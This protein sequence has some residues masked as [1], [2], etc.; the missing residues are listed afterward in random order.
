[1]RA[2]AC[3]VPL[4]VVLGED[5]YLVREGLARLLATR[6]EI[7][8]AAACA[9]GDSVLA[10]VEAE[11]P[12]VVV[13]DIRMPPGAADEGIRLADRLRESHP[14]VGVVVLSQY[15]DAGF[16]LALL[17]G[18][19]AGRAYL[20]KERVHDIDE[21]VAAIG[22]VAA[23][24]SVIDP[25][26]VDGLVQAGPDSQDS[27][28]GELTPREREILAEMARGKNNA[29]IAASLI[30]TEGTVEKYVSS[31]FAKLGISWEKDV[32][33]RV[34]AVLVYLGAQQR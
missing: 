5:D 33:R 21:L 24:R 22:A 15:C 11:S 23:G 1:M 13:T 34:R 18:G 26:I 3:G 4:R 14:A 30:I 25:R 31:I 17:A 6:P 16:A 20:L 29:A 27:A 12:D 19:S 7:E 2:Y 28:I 32:H 10:A 8:V 9:D